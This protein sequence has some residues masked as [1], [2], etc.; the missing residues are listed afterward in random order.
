[1]SSFRRRVVRAS[2][3]LNRLPLELKQIVVDFARNALVDELRQ[4]HGSISRVILK[5]FEHCAA[6][7]GS[8]SASALWRAS[9]HQEHFLALRDAF[10][11]AHRYRMSLE[12]EHVRSVLA[13]ATQNELH[14]VQVCDKS[15][16]WIACQAYAR[17]FAAAVVESH[18]GSEIK[19]C[20]CGLRHIITRD[21][22]VQ[23]MSPAHVIEAAV[24]CTGA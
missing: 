2:T 23:C 16:E 11:L 20:C 15:A 9:H 8:P 24:I 22:A 21:Q 18:V 4:L 13:A 12:E 1:M 7:P 10:I 5:R 19:W 6:K 14:C 17:V 3:L